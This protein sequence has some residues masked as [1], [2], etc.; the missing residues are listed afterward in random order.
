[1]VPWELLDRAPIPGNGGELCLYRRGGEY[2]I[3]ANGRQLMNSVAHH[4]EELLADHACSRLAA[5][6]RPRVLVGGLGMGF[7]LV[8][9]LRHLGDAGEVV[10]AELI[11]AVVEWNHGPLGEVAG[12]PLRDDRVTIRVADVATLLRSETQAYDAILLD[13]DNGPEGLTHPAND[14]LYTPQGLQAAAAALRPGGVVAVWSAGPDPRFT[15][16]LCRTDLAAE[17]I[18]VRGGYTIWIG[19]K[20][21]R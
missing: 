14:W 3:R 15:A 20:A 16:R 17:E 8:A 1:M 10:V 12:H 13:V 9:L 4:S 6:R 2:S 7:T 21:P 5:T 19:R 18:R 11:P